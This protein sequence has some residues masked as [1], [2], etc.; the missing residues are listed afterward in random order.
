MDGRLL[1]ALAS[2]EPMPPFANEVCDF[3]DLEDAPSCEPLGHDDNDE[4]RPKTFDL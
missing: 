3:G 2:K 4:L 1:S